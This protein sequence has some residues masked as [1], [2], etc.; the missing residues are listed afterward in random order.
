M[1]SGRRS[2]VFVIKKEN[3]EKIIAFFI[4]LLACLQ[5]ISI[6]EFSGF[7]LK[8]IHIL[9]F[10][11]IPNLCKKK[12]IAIYPPI[13][14]YVMYVILLSLIVSLWFPLKGFIF[15]YVFGLAIYLYIINLDKSMLSFADAQKAIC[16]SMFII[17]AYV[18]INDI[19][20]YKEF[21]S[22]FNNPWNGHPAISTVF[23]G[24]PN[25]EASWIGMFSVFF[26]S[27]KRKWIYSTGSLII[28]IS[29]ASRAG[30]LIN[31]MAIG[32]MNKEAII[33]DKK[34]ILAFLVGIVAVMWAFS[35]GYLGIITDRFSTMGED[36]GSE[37]R[38][39]NLRGFMK[40]FEAFPFGYGIGNCM[41]S[42]RNVTESISRDNNMH[43]VYL[44]NFI[45]LGFIGGTWY[46]LLALVFC[47]R[48]RKQMFANTF[49]MF[50]Y[51]Y[52]F[53]S[54]FEFR[55]GDTLFFII[56]GF[57]SLYYKEDFNI[58]TRKKEKMSNKELLS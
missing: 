32:L 4:I 39:I 15:N 8:P 38:L 41:D 37:G 17:I 58:D 23:G 56:L 42:I 12:R 29:Y 51:I 46:I 57:Y 31:I 49:A 6:V 30:I 33:K 53:V 52:L 54:L 47:I 50:I 3:K 9:L 43:N 28:S 10:L 1:L 48:S 19:L 40:T 11:L 26:I 36:K 7:A 34:T 45:E 20:Q 44:Q 5:N 55:G 14:A 27:D 13:V 16:D 2:G 25:V 18:L 21:I 24:G 35:K 22:F